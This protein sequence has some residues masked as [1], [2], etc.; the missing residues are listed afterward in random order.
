MKRR[1]LS[2]IW[3]EGEWLV[4]AALAIA[5][6]VLGYLG[7]ARHFA[8]AGAVRTT[9]DMVYLVLQLFTMESGGVAPPVPWELEVARL[10][11]PFVALYAAAKA[12]LL[13]FAEQL[14][15]TQL[16]RMRDHAV[17]CGGGREGLALARAFR[18]RG[19]RVVLIE[20]NPASRS[21]AAARAAG[22]TV[23]TGD[24][25]DPETLQ[26]ARLARAR[27]VLVVCGSD[28]TNAEVAVAVRD[29]AVDARER[30]I[31]CA[32]HIAD[33]ELCHLLRNRWSA[34]S[35][36]RLA[37]IEFFNI[38]DHGARALLD[39]FPPGATGGMSAGAQPHLLVVGLGRFGESLVLQAAW[40]ARVGSSRQPNSRPLAI[41]VIDLEAGQKCEMLCARHGALAEVC[42]IRPLAMD[43]TSREFAEAAFMYG[44]EGRPDVTCV[45][46]CLDDETRALSAGLILQ[47]RSRLNRV[48]VVVRME[49]DTGLASL[50]DRRA[51]D[52]DDS[53]L[54][55]FGLLDRAC[56]PEYALFG[57]LEA[58]AQALHEQYVR[59]MAVQGDTSAANPSLVAWDALGDDLK[60]ANRQQAA[61]LRSVL[62]AAGFEIE[63]RRSWGAEPLRFSAE[64]I[65]RLA[66]A[67]HER[68][69][70]ER[71]SARWRFAPGQK[72]QRRRT[73][74]HL[75]PWVELPEDVREIDRGVFR[76]LP[77]LLAD[78]GY[79][80]TVSAETQGALS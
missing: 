43:A 14:Q 37:R 38:F 70:S 63:A 1:R 47:R 40:R 25:A 41:T 15:H 24:A 65:E 34:A 61:G 51:A 72:D 33:P 16:W 62:A 19:F 10:L 36:S 76:E 20:E 7:F 12:L 67:E 48:P 58:L 28:G 30:P 75:L 59:R 52:S 56:T 5:A 22:A 77:M 39:Q 31:T 64:E 79:A 50:F 8:A 13:L 32:V 57:T 29:A 17:V 2:G 11:A 18:E 55:L 45:Y 46:V 78:A 69:V 80:V 44:T 3:R 23:L 26:R 53:D 27:W 60:G 68:W 49:R 6:M 4:I 42:A 9:W 71:R 54:N 74:P 21:A 35:S 66:Q 73:T